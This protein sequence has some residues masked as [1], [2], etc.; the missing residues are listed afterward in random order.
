VQHTRLS[1]GP[2]K[3]IFLHEGTQIKGLAKGHVSRAYQRYDES[4]DSAFSGEEVPPIV[5]NITAGSKV[6]VVVFGD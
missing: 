3:S 6:M 4:S 2:L 5:G 1:R